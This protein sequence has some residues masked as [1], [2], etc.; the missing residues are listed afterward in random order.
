MCEKNCTIQLSSA[1]PA[2]ASKS[3]PEEVCSRKQNW[4]LD[5]SNHRETEWIKCF[6]RDFQCRLIRAEIRD[7]QLCSILKPFKQPSEENTVLKSVRW[8]NLLTSCISLEQ[9]FQIEVALFRSKVGLETMSPG[10][11]TRG[12][13][14]SSQYPNGSSQPWFSFQGRTPSSCLQQHQ[15]CKH[16]WKQNTCTYKNKIK[17]Y[18]RLSICS[19]SRTVVVQLH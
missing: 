1:G 4:L 10:C 14:F 18:S 16:T 2:L 11:S 13:D 5:S 3:E 7:I 12:P 17:N 8:P 9:C 15:A 6:L 19:P